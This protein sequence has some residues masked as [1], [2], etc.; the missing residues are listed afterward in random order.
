VRCLIDISNATI[1]AL[2]CLVV[3][4]SQD[5]GPAKI[6]G[7]VQ[8]GQTTT[9]L[10]ARLYSPKISQ[11]QQSA[12]QVEG[13]VRRVRIAYVGDDGRFEFQGLRADSYLLEIYSGDRLLY[14]KVVSTQDSQPLEITIA[15]GNES[16]QSFKKKGWRPIRL[17]VYSCWPAAVK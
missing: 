14:Q 5:S 9:P 8:F 2:T 15:G 3:A 17:P 6:A 11:A 10:V 4:W 13:D 16:T 1:I 7:H 12:Q